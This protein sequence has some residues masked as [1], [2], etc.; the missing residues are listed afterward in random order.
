MVGV[1]SRRAKI[2]L[3]GFLVIVALVTAAGMWKLWPQQSLVDELRAGKVSTPAG[4]SYEKAKILTLGDCP[5]TVTARAPQF[6]CLAA[7]ALVLTGPEANA[8]VDFEIVGPGAIAGLQPGDRVVA[9]RLP[10]ADHI[11]YAYGGVER[12]GIVLAM[13]LLFVVSVLAV[14]RW[15][16]FWALVG[17]VFSGAVIAVFTLPALAIGR[18]GVTVGLIGSVAI[19]FVVL[20][21]AHGVSFRT[22]AALA[23]TILGL[24]I[25]TGLGVVAVRLG[26]LSGYLDEA[27]ASLLGRF[28][29][30]NLQD[31]LVAAMTV[32]GLGVL[33]DVTITQ[34]SAVWELR[35]AGPQLSR[36]EIFQSGMRIGRDHIA[37][38]IYTIVFAYTGAAIST[39][40]LLIMFNDRPWLD[41]LT[42]ETFG[43]EVLRTLA[44]ATGLVLCVPITT[45]LA[46]MTVRGAHTP[47][48]EVETALD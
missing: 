31:L 34:T 26:R 47:S 35:A 19:I 25:S 46:A 44:S 9:M 13:T 21:V 16:G 40:M 43:G 12:G 41:L 20:Y 27:D 24:F 45:A 28:P 17:L 32:A 48:A 37:S 1:T 23:G 42:T 38:T 7:H 8:E 11:A 15:R 4:V 39:L 3:I 14:A 29:M 5:S 18:S 30:M 2:A 6:S 36:W 22:T 10:A 33:N